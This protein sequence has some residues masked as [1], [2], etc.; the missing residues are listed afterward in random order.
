MTK[1]QLR[2]TLLAEGIIERLFIPAYLK[3]LALN[4]SISFKNS[5]KGNNVYSKSKVLKSI[6]NLVSDFVA[7]ETEHLFIMGVDLDSDVINDNYFNEIKKLEAEIH[8]YVPKDKIVIFVAVQSFDYWMY[9]Q[10]NKIHK[11]NSLEKKN[12]TDIKSWLYGTSQPNKN[13]TSIAFNKIF[14]K[15]DFELLSKQSKSFNDFHSKIKKYISE[16]DSSNKS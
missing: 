8:Q 9:Y 7:S 11:S 15:I 16:N 14:D 10:S 2:Y 3:K 6:K 12:R 1:K 5:T 13:D 4:T